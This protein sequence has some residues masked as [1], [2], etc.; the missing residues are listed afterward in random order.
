MKIRTEKERMERAAAAFRA[1]RR[2][3]ALERVRIPIYR[4]EG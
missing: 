2:A 3:L 1:K 4:K